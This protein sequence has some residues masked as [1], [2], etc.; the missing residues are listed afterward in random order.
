MFP[1]VNEISTLF[2][3]I[4][5]LFSIQSILHKR[6]KEVMYQILN[7]TNPENINLQIKK[8]GGVVNIN[9]LR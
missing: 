7:V 1:K 2:I 9:W 3:F 5:N 6:M 8:G 4:T